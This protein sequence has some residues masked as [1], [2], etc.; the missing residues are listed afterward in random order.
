MYG[1]RVRAAGEDDMKR[2]LLTI[3]VCLLLGA[4][5][6]SQAVQ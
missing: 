5:V 1:V 3:A 4:V 2:H 6:N